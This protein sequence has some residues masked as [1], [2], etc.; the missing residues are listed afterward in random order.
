[1]SEAEQAHEHAEHAEHA[2]HSNE[3]FTKRVAAA[4]AITAAVLALVS[5]LGSMAAT[6]ELLMEVKASDAWA[7][8]QAKSIR[9][10]Q[11]EVTAGV[12]QAL[13]QPALSAGLKQQAAK[14]RS[15][16]DEIQKRAKEFE[17]ESAG[18]GRKA[19]RLH[20]GEIFLEMAI[21]L[22]SLAI[23][24]HKETMFAAAIAAGVAGSLIA[25]SAYVLLT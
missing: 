1:M 20:L 22:S 18:L 9:R 3:P 23:L 4:M 2:A 25:A 15:D 11:S 10:Y 12:L 6:E 24:T 7:Q 17:T 16:Q 13:N 8:Y 5:V 21:V 14:Y 19:H